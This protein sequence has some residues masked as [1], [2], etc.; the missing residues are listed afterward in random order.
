MLKTRLVIVISVLLI[1]GAAKAN[2]RVT[3]LEADIDTLTNRISVLEQMFIQ[4]AANHQV[5][6]D[7]VMSNGGTNAKSAVPIGKA[8]WRKLQKGMSYEQV[9]LL[10]GAPES[11][12]VA[13]FSYWEY[14]NYGSVRFDNDRVDG[15][16]EPD[17]T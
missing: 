17:N 15:W 5:V 14:D 3:Q 9:E 6:L 11:V 16:T 12:R 1:A 8:A 2:E 7:L 10:L 13:V 4:S